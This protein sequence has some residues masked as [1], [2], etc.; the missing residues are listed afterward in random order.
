MLGSLRRAGSAPALFGEEGVAWLT[1][2]PS[3][4]TDPCYWE[5]KSQQLV[6]CF[7]DRWAGGEAGALQAE[8]G[9]GGPQ[10]AQG[11]AEP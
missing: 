3:M 6:P 5:R 4:G 7:S 1:C 10:T 11:E 2:H 9:G 8:H